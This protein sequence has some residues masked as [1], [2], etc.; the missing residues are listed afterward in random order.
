M[1]LQGQGGVS[2]R[3][4]PFF[5][6]CLLGGAVGDALGAPV[7]FMSLGQIQAQFGPSGIRDFSPAYGK[8][9][10][11]TD[12]TQMT[13]FTAEGLIRGHNR[14]MEKGIGGGTVTCVYHAYLRW[15][16]SQGEQPSYPFPEV[17]E[18]WLLTIPQLWECRAPGNTCLAALRAGIMGTM[19]RPINSSKGCG[20]V[21]RVAPVGLAGAES[22]Q[23]GCE[24][25]AITHGHPTGYLAA[26]FLSALIDGLIAGSDLEDAISTARHTL[27][28]YPNHQEC[29]LAIDAAITL[30]KQAPPAPESLERLGSGWVAEEALAIALFCALTVDDFE[31]AVILAVNHSGDSD[32]TGALTGNILG[33]LLGKDATPS[34][35]L[36]PLE[37]HDEIEQVAIDLFRH[38]G[39]SE[40]T[41]SPEEDWQRY[42]GW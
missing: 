37:L 7:E 35:W 19:A 17:R 1:T 40:R 15:L 13:L 23:L 38:F 22:F 18:G 5:A 25:A 11:V 6:G 12:D 2:H 14:A 21:M 16:E 29:L 8:L 4:L 20:T 42:P 34:K 26:G 28:T 24:T 10:A 41:L 33:A 31:D 9:A 30:A 3:S 39:H 36:G 27:L 32:S